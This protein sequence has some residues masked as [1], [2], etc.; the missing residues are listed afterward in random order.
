MKLIVNQTTL[1]L[2]GNNYVEIWQVARVSKYIIQKCIPTLLKQ[3]W[4]SDYNLFLVDVAS[5]EFSPS[6]EMV[7]LKLVHTN[8]VDLEIR[9]NQIQCR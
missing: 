1:M 2:A 7:S 5:Y 6:E 4:N 3:C 8:N 9:V